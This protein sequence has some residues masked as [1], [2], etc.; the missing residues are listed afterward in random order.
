M[1]E[2]HITIGRIV[3]TF[4]LKGFIKVWPDTDFPERFG[5][6]RVVFLEGEPKKIVGCRW[7]KT[8]VRIRLEGFTKIGQAE[9]VIGK[10]LTVPASDKPELEPGEY[11][12]SDLIG[13]K[14][15]DESGRLLGS[16][17]EVIP[18]P[19][20]DIYRIGDMMVPAVSEF[21]RE[22]DL[23]ARRMILRLIPGMEPVPEAPKAPPKRVRS[24]RNEK[25]S[26]RSRRRSP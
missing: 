8:Q 7:H 4:G 11:M 17:D 18:A 5:E 3:G 2:G 12:V 22:V 21:I 6:G 24:K 13:L 10:D 26:H 19:A 23:K 16:L 25:R 15:Y 14:V 20:A 9:T 1:P